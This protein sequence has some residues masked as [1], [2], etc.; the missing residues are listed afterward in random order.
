[1]DAKRLS[2]LLWA[3]AQTLKRWSEDR[4]KA[5]QI[6]PGREDD[7]LSF[8]LLTKDPF[9]RTYTALLPEMGAAAAD[10]KALYDKVKATLSVT[11]ITDGQQWAEA[12]VESY[13]DLVVRCQLL[14]REMATDQRAGAS[15]EEWSRPMPLRDLADRVL[16]D[17]TKHRKLKALYEPDRLK[18]IGGKGSQS[19]QIRLDGLP[20]NIRKEIERP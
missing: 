19:W 7:R 13:G 17:P 4:G 2:D 20:A 15:P 18:Q 3:F 5:G 10:L 1:M 6:I 12:L 14:A 11:E 16:K 9:E 8:L